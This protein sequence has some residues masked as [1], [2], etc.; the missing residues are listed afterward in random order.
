MSDLIRSL[1]LFVRLTEEGSFSALG[2]SQNLSHTTIAR[3][4]SDL[5]LHFGVRLFQRTTRRQVLTTDGERLLEHAVAIL[6]QVGLAESD[7]AGAVAARGLVRIGVTTAL[8]LHYAER[9]GRLS[10]QH[11]ELLV[12]WLMADWH[13]ATDH[14]GLDLWLWVGEDGAEGTLLGHLPRIL[15]ASPGYLRRHGVPVSVSDLAGHQCLAYG[16]AA[17]PSPWLL[18]GKEF[19]LTGFLRANSSEA[20]LRAARGGG[21]IGLLPRI[22]VEEDLARGLLTHVLPQVAIPPVAVLIAHG[23]RGMRMPMRTRVALDFLVEHFPHPPG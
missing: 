13:D 10:E 5:E 12:E 4:I 2:R 18:E 6:D 20:I 9:L 17:R 1:R 15:A 16:Y 8:G 7:L 11:P 19:S 21:G 23:F 22:Q 3:A 14:G